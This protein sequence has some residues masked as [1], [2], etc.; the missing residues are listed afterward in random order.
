MPGDSSREERL[1]QFSARTGTAVFLNASVR[2]P[3][4]ANQLTQVKETAPRQGSAG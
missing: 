1:D 4:S 2:N 3:N